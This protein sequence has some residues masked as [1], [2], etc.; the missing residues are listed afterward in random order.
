MACPLE[1][2]NTEE[3]NFLSVFHACLYV[4]GTLQEFIDLFGRLL[5]VLFIQLME[6]MHVGK[7]VFCVFIYFVC[8]STKLMSTKFGTVGLLYTSLGELNFDSN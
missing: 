5:S 7:Y 2:R 1:L 3:L 8:E 4:F 6:T